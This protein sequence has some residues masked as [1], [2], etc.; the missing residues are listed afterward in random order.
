[1][2]E[3]TEFKYSW[4]DGIEY[5]LQEL[6]KNTIERSEF[7]K[8]RY[9]YLKGYLKYFRIPTIILSG[10]N[11]VFSVGLQPYCP[12]KTVSAICCLISLIC[13]I[14][15]SIELFLSIQT[16][17]EKELAASKEY[18]LLSVDIFKVLFLERSKRMM[19]G[20][21]YLD[22][23]YQKYCKIVESSNL[24]NH[25]IPNMMNLDILKMVSNSEQ[26]KTNDVL[27]LVVVDNEEKQTNIIVEEEQ[28]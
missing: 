1:M 12:Q 11:S 4:S 13:G 16:T 19:N 23:T 17:M 2:S 24:V 7:H 8:K 26:Y 20:K 25:S 5:V 27:Q 28:N 22:D 6:Y 10:M 14:I 9:R 3:L 21:T 18:Y 15:S